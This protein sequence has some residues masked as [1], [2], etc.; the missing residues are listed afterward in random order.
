M[1][2]I[3]TNATYNQIAS[4]D[5]DLST[6]L[7][8]QKTKH[9]KLRQDDYPH[10]DKC[11]N[12]SG[13]YDKFEF[14]DGYCHREDCRDIA[15]EPYRDPKRKVTTAI[16]INFATYSLDNP[17]IITDEGHIYLIYAEISGL[18]KIGRSNELENRFST[19]ATANSEPLLLIHSFYSINYKAAESWMHRKFTNERDHGEWFSLSE[20]Q[21]NWVK[22]IGDYDLDTFL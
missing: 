8:F 1:V 11:L 14:P 21:V 17:D 19:L 6:R 3:P 16:P 15:T 18:Y 10:W 22:S 13:V 9:T 12:C 5:M 4:L 20:S 2:Y 7:Q